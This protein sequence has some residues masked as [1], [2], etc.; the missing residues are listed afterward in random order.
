MQPGRVLLRATGAHSL[1][2]FKIL[3]VPRSA[4]S[5]Q[6]KD[7]Y[8]SLVKTHHPDLPSSSK[9]KNFE[10]KDIVSAYELLRDPRRREAYVRYGLGWSGG[11]AG[12]AGAAGNAMRPDVGFNYNNVHNPWGDPKT[13]RHRHAHER[14]R[15][16]SS[17]WDFGH[18]DTTDFYSSNSNAQS[19]SSSRDGSGVYTSNASFMS[20]LA[21][22]SLLLYSVQFWRLAPPL[23]SSS[24]AATPSS[25]SSSLNDISFDNLA[26][27]DPR[28]APIYRQSSMMRGRDK[29]HEDAS[30][31]LGKARQ[32]AQKWGTVRRDNI[33]SG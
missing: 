30:R 33:R 25:S 21:G 24:D 26:A 13:R 23:P 11:G 6:I 15:Y 22:M 14:G 29:H 12:G 19:S 1:D 17:S 28:S 5:R 8:Y 27:T 2:P 3:D 4:T 18:S 10:F 9:P 32:N 7:A 20:I 16:P 31:A